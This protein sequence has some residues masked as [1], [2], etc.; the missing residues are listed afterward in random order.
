MPTRANQL[1]GR[2]SSFDVQQ[3]AY[4]FWIE[5]TVIGEHTL[6][7]SDTIQIGRRE[8]DRLG[9]SGL[10]NLFHAHLVDR[11]S[12]VLLRMICKGERD[13][14]HFPSLIHDDRGRHHKA[15]IILIENREVELC[16]TLDLLAIGQRAEAQT[17]NACSE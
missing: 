5:V 15:D 3:S 13:S 10:H 8:L 11:E 4:V 2:H 6:I 9:F 7:G 16:G 12:L 1:A 14:T 17:E